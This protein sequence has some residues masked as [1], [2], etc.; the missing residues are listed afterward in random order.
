MVYYLSSCCLLLCLDVR[1]KSRSARNE[2]RTVFPSV[3]IYEP[4][5]LFT[6]LV[7]YLHFY[8][9]IFCLGFGPMVFVDVNSIRSV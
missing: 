7:E 5:M 1:S 9:G 3:V 4:V 8:L 2:S 6:R